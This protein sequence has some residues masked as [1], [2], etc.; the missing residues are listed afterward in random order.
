MSKTLHGILACIAMMA[1]LYAIFVY[2]P[3]ELT[4]GIVQKIFYFHV[5]S[6]WIGFLAIYFVFVSSVL[7]LM[8]GTR[9]W[10]MRAASAAEVG[11]IFYTLN[12]LSGPLWAKPV[13]GIWWTWD[14]R[15]TTSFVLWL[16]YMGY[17]MLRRL[18]DS[19]EQRARL[20]AVFSVLGAVDAPIVYMAN[21]WWRTQH[22]QPV[23]GGGEGSGLEP[24]MRIAFYLTLVAFTTF[25]L[26]L[27]RVRCKLEQTL[28]VVETLERRIQTQWEKAR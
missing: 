13:W 7:F 6:A 28:D 11:A 2:A 26:Y 15:L 8:K 24:Q 9:E 17:L 20:C 12:L 18:V 21:R 4:M 1:S 3:V 27:W 19:P 14:M 22:P 5:A 25:F 23:M 16:V 10:D